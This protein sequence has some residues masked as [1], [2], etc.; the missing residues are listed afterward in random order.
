MKFVPRVEQYL[1]EKATLIYY[2]FRVRAELSIA[3][4]SEYTEDP[5]NSPIEQL[6]MIGWEARSAF[7]GDNINYVLEPQFSKEELTGSYRLDFRIAVPPDS[8]SPALDTNGPLI[9]IELDGHEWHEK[10]K[11]Q[12]EYDKKRDRY[13]AAKGWH[14]LRFTGAEIFRDPDKAIEE[15]VS[16]CKAKAVSPETRS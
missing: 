4:G 8:D 5:I 2:D 12:A 14:I 7:V 10:T 1:Q 3:A 9:G 11:R 6:F 13:L 16:F 15:V